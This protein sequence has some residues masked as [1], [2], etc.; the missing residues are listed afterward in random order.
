MNQ[1]EIQNGDGLNMEYV[2]SIFDLPTVHVVTKCK[3]NARVILVVIFYI[4][5]S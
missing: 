4:R 1:Q 2:N 3:E 5:Q